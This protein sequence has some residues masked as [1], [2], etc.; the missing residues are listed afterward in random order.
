[1]TRSAFPRIIPTA[2]QD[3][4]RIALA[5]VQTKRSVIVIRHHLDG[6]PHEWGLPQCPAIVADLSVT[7]D[8]LAARD[9]IDRKC[10]VLIFTTAH[11]DHPSGFTY[12]PGETRLIN[13]L[14]WRSAAAAGLLECLP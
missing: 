5:A 4:P 8:E 14:F 12:G 3:L 13:D 6:G 9:F 11:G 10:D 1:M 7:D 2:F